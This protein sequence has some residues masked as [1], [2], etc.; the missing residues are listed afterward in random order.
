[1]ILFA[2]LYK[3][4]ELIFLYKNIGLSVTSKSVNYTLANSLIIRTVLT[5]IYMFQS[6]GKKTVNP[7]MFS[8]CYTCN[9]LTKGNLLRF[10]IYIY[11]F[12][13]YSPV[14]AQLLNFSVAQI[15]LMTQ[16]KLTEFLPH[17]KGLKKGLEDF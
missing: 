2:G 10:L 17:L 5:Y 12:H 3:S 1:M 13:Q 7:N 15:I 8:G 11:S 6:A 4:L 16:F 9:F 14:F